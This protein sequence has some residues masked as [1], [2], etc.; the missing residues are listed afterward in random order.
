MLPTVAKDARI[1]RYGYM[2]QWFGDFRIQATLVRVANL[3]LVDLIREREVRLDIRT[4]YA[5]QLLSL[6]N[7]PNR[8]MIFIAHCFGGLAL[9]QASTRSSQDF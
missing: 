5:A 1:M 8:P 2:S 4:Y 6:Q 9:A 7:C 3:F